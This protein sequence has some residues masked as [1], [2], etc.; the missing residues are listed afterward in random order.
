LSG[1]LNLL[2]VECIA[3]DVFELISVIPT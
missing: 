2:E 3:E 1:Y